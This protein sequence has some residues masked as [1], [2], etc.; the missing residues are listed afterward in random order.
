MS[1]FR[2][3]PL[4]GRT[5]LQFRVEGFSVTNHPQWSNPNGSVTSGNFM[6]ITHARRGGR[7]LRP[8][9]AEIGLL[10]V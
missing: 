6:R 9:R 3:F 4:P 10:S 8:A 5:R 2:T 7:A 1:V